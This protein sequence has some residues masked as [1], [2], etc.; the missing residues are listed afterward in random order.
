MSD[1][2]EPIA[3][4]EETLPPMSQRRILMAMAATTIFGG[5]LGFTFVSWQFGAGVLF[6]GSLSLVN[7][8]WLKASLKAVFA[9]AVAGEKPRFLAGKY[10]LRY[11]AFGAILL[12][13]FL[14]KT[15]PVI[16]V[17]LGL[18]SFAFAIV[19]EALILLFA[20]FFKK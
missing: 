20:S 13:V 2:S 16:S 18:A 19:I 12:I 3:A 4:Q 14:T 11:A 9:K 7:Y 17:L 1:D 6:G 8:Y 15:L 5:L 10:F